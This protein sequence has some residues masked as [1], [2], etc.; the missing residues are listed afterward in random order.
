MNETTSDSELQAALD[1]LADLRAVLARMLESLPQSQR[2]ADVE[3]VL[4]LDRPLAWR[5]FRTATAASAAETF[6][7]LPTFKQLQRI[8]TVA[9]ERGLAERTLSAISVQIERFQGAM[10]AV[11]EDRAAFAAL[12]YGHGTEGPG[13]LELRVRKQAFKCN[14]HLWGM[15]CRSLAFAAVFRGKAPGAAMDAIAARGWIDVYSSSVRTGTLLLSRFRATH[16]GG[17]EP[18]GGTRVGRM[19]LV[20]GFGAPDQPTLTTEPGAGG[21]QESH[22]QLKGVGRLSRT[23]VY[24]RML[25]DAAND[26]RT[27]VG[28]AHTPCL[29][30]ESMHFDLIVPSGWADPATMEAMMHARP[31]DVQRAAERRVEDR[32]PCHERPAY[33]PGVENVP[34]SQAVPHWPD[35]MRHLLRERGWW[36]R[37]FDVFRLHI[38]YP[39]L[40]ASYTLEVHPRGEAVNENR[41]GSPGGGSIHGMR[42][43]G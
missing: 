24:T 30:A 35:L 11:A 2:A 29:P 20:S 7:H 43:S 41:P 19:E 40:H 18:S 32:V 14:A 8:V 31:H 34:P 22:I 9:R 39:V 23:N 26:P 15:Q 33:I 13:A 36:G 21:F 10:G 17:E 27:K 6:Q 38:A 5:L 16:K 25:V 42:G 3:Q 4:G 37:R 28:I 1:A 12:L